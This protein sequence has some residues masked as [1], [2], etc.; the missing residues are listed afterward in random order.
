MITAQE[1]RE[2]VKRMDG[3]WMR[4]IKV[5]HDSGL[6]EIRGLLVY[7]ASVNENLAEENE[8]LKERVTELER[9]AGAD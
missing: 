8:R 4:L 5:L 9:A 1:A 7:L 3:L 6:D 2:A